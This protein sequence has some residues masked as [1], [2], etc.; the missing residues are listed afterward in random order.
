MSDIFQLVNK[1]GARMAVYSQ[2]DYD[3]MTARGWKLYPTPVAEV[4]VAE[5]ATPKKRG[6]PAKVEH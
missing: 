2:R 4:A 1:E 5:V 3:Y 6:R